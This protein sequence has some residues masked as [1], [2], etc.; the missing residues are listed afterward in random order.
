MQKLNHEYRE[1]LYL[2]YY[3]EMSYE[4]AGIVMKKNKKQIDNLAYR[5]KKQ[6]K[7]IIEKERFYEK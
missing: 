4:M 3:V 5:A 1:I 6:L 2:I 7:Y